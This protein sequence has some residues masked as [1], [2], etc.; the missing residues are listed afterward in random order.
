MDHLEEEVI[1]QGKLD[2]LIEEAQKLY[3]PVKHAAASVI[4][5]FRN[6]PRPSVNL[7]SHFKLPKIESPKFNGKS[8]SD[9]S[10]F[11]GSFE[12]TIHNATVLTKQ[13][14]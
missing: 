13:E 6:S 3:L 12:E 5:S 1:W 2:D 7:H 9:W 8:L 14:E 10:V 11:C 4:S